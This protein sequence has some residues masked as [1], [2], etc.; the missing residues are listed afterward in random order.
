LLYAALEGVAFTVREA[1]DCLLASG[2]DVPGLRMAGGGTTA[3]VWRQML[4]DVLE[5]PLTPI[6][7][8]GASAL[9]ATVLARQV[10][11]LPDLAPAVEED[12]P[13]ATTFPRAESSR[14]HRR[15]YARYREQVAALRFPDPQQSLTPPPPAREDR[16]N[17]ATH[18]T[19]PGPSTSHLGS[20]R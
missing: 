5:R 11:G 19:A 15:R 14:F 4:A 12:A 8:P 10:A 1:A 6:H 2:D 17:H 7:V 18:P 9:G 16:S 3:P 20:R 13:E